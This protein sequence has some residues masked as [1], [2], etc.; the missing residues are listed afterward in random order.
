MILTIND[1]LELVRVFC[2]GSLLGENYKRMKI[3]GLE[4][5]FQTINRESYMSALVLLNFF[6][7]LRKR[8]K[9]QGFPSILSLFATSLINSIKQEHES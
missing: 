7:K 5:K 4:E 8:D 2:C 3:L 9:I 1:N 6:N